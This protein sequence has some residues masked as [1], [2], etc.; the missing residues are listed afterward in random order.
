VHA[1][2]AQLEVACRGGVVHQD[3]DWRAELV[4]RLLHD[5]APVGVDVGQVG[6]DASARPPADSM[7]STVCSSDP[8]YSPSPGR[9]V[10]AVTATRAPSAASRCAI[11]RPMP[12]L[13]PVTTATLPSRLPT[14]LLPLA[15]CDRAQADAR[16]P[17]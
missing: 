9:R 2:E 15:A 17:P 3:L 7:S 14:V 12:R 5:L 11:P 6:D 13:A 8:A 10:R 4:A 16:I 1:L